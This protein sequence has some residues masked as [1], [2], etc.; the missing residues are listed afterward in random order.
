MQNENKLSAMAT[1]IVAAAEQE[2]ARLR[3]EAEHEESEV[4]AECRRAAGESA[5]K[6]I[7]AAQADARARE[8]KRV[9]TA[10]FAGRRTLLRFREDCANEV[11]AAVRER[12]RQAAASGD[13]PGLLAS[14]LNKGLAAMAGARSARVLLRPED[15]VHADA[16]KEAAEG[17]V[18]LEFEEGDFLLGGLIV[19]CPE[20]S[21]LADLSFDSA[22]EDLK[23]RFSEIT[24]FNVEG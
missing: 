18:E 13:Y 3:G 9:V 22:L 2:A 6:R 11:F 5:E 4:L 17:D 8:E 24:G 23:G 7:A 15:M 1:A 16:L 14:L 20:L 10:S 21:R 12:A 19:E